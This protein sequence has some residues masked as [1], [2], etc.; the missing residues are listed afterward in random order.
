MQENLNLLSFGICGI[1]EDWVEIMNTYSSVDRMYYILE[2]GAGYIENGEKHYFIKNHIYILN[3]TLNLQYFSESNRFFHAFIKFSQILPPRQ[4]K[5]M[6]ADAAQ[7]PVLKAD[8]DAFL[9][10]M[11]HKTNSSIIHHRINTPAVFLEHYER[12][13]LILKSIF[14]DF[15]MNTSLNPVNDELIS[16]SLQYIR[17]HFS[18]DISVEKLAQSVNLSKN[19]FTRRFVNQVHM[20]PYQYIKRYRF[21]AAL[22]MLNQGVPINDIAEKCGFLSA[23]AFSNSFK[24]NFGH[25]PTK[26]FL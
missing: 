10:Y 12:I 20:P 16:V 2:E 23:S 9:A 8:I 3:H 21:G 13:M 4:E 25:P 19:Q 26:L 11:T 15:G 5:V 24:K 6:Y 18:E 1:K 17:D 14:Y 22:S 7:S